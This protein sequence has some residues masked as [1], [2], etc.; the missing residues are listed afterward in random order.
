[1]KLWD[2]Q[3]FSNVSAR[4][5]R[6]GIDVSL[7]KLRLSCFRTLKAANVDVGTLPIRSLTTAKCSRYGPIF[8]KVNNLLSLQESMWSS[9]IFVCRKAS[10][11]MLKCGTSKRW[12]ACNFEKILLLE[13]WQNWKSQN[14]L[15]IPDPE[16]NYSKNLDVPLLW[17][18]CCNVM[19]PAPFKIVWKSHKE[20]W[21]FDW[22]ILEKVLY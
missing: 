3:R 7:L 4:E 1:M 19:N 21:W 18:G 8:F 10:D 5:L 16:Y 15:C 22:S 14:S 12:I 17:Y 11:W 6:S 2:N 9:E 20:T 13:V